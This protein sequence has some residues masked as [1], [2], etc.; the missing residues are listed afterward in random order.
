[1]KTTIVMDWRGFSYVKSVD[2]LALA[3][4][5]ARKVTVPS[6]TAAAAARLTLD[7]FGGRSDALG[8]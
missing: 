7:D 3:G 5:D 4:G 2:D 1:L 6:E 8:G